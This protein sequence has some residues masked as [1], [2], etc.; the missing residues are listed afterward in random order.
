MA[1]VVPNGID[2]D[3]FARSPDLF[4][5]AMMPVT[6]GKK[7]P[8]RIIVVVKPEP[9]VRVEVTYGNEPAVLLSSSAS[10]AAELS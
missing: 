5:P 4:E 7:T 8:I 1:P 3:P 10:H 2:F 9:E 6:D